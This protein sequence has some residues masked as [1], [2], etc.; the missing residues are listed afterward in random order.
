[1]GAP[2]VLIRRQE[3]ERFQVLRV[4]EHAGLEGELVEVGLRGQEHEVAEAEVQS[5]VVS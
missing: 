4:A 5:K 2:I 3:N 1:M